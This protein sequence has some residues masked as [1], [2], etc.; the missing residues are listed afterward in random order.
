MLIERM[1][2]GVRIFCWII[3]LARVVEPSLTWG[4]IN[5]S[6][7]EQHVKELLTLSIEELMN[8]DITSVAKKAQP[9]SDAAAAAYVITQEDIQRSGLRSIPEI[10]RLAPGVQVARVDAN[11]WSI[12]I[13]GLNG[14]FASSLLVLIDGRSIY[15]PTFG[16]VFWDVQD[17]LLE[18][19]ERIEVVR[20]PGGT[21][22]GANA[23]NGVINIITKKA[24]ATQGAY[25]IG[26]AGTLERGYGGARYGGKIGEKGAYRIYGKYFNRN[27]FQKPDGTD[28]DD[29]W[30]QGRGG[31][32]TDWNLSTDDT[33]TVQGDG[34]VGRMNQ[35]ALG[36]SLTPPFSFSA[37]NSIDVAGA[38]IL[39]RWDHQFSPASQTT[40]Q[41]YYDRT[42]RESLFFG[43]DRDTY[44]VDFQHRWQW[45]ER[46]DI[47]WGLGYRLSRDTVTNNTFRL[48]FDPTD[49]DFQIISGFLQDEITLIPDR[50]RLTLGTKVS[51][52][53]FT[54]MEYQPNG[55]LLWKPHDLHTLWAAVSRAVRIPT[56]VDD[57]IRLNVAG[58]P[59]AG[60]PG[61]AVTRS[62]GN[63][64]FKSVELVAYEAG[65]RIQAIPEFSIDLAGF[66]HVYRGLTSLQR[67][68][69]FIETTPGPTHVVIPARFDN[70]VNGNAYGIE[71]ATHWQVLE[72]WRVLANYSWLRMR[73]DPDAG[74]TG[75][76]I[77]SQPGSNPKHTF[78]AR[79]LLNLPYNLA[80]D[81]NVFYVSSLPTLSVSKYIR[82]DVRLGWRP[83]NSV[84][85]SLVGQNVFDNQHP[86]FA[87]SG[88]AALATS[89]EVPRGGYVQVTWR[90]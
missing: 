8:M 36:V 26:G 10:L 14:L 4:A 86:E 25:L 11:R 9:L 57:G 53:T 35:T 81:T 56:R 16:G 65:Y 46:Q 63:K 71:V 90:W 37:P 76:P 30:S 12:S 60:P 20:G 51:H 77:G 82:V 43:E 85:V 69:S 49:Q 54:G 45:G 39:M 73:L 78:H 62:Q 40:L 89:T 79:S 19:I 74:N 88:P 18:D 58:L 64:D 75:P 22:W 5:M 1:K 3:I 47:V 66:Y 48:S 41:L 80:F 72:N 15:T 6:Q 24:Q 67:E 87:L 55:R 13:R 31:F 42:E 27:H 33:V 23:V 52:N 7:E 50:L 17:T 83:T 29:A 2:T 84:D 21:L 59:T 34:Y 38:N 68:E 32:R 61:V 44:D 70:R 28:A